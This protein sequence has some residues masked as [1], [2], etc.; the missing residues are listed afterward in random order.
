MCGRYVSTR[1]ARD[2]VDLFDVAWW[3]AGLVLAPSWNV[4]P[5]D[6]VW[7]VLERVDQDSGEVTRQLRLL[8]WGLVPLW[9]RSL[10]VGSKMINARVEKTVAQKPAFRRAWSGE[11]STASIGCG[12]R[13]PVRARCPSGGSSAPSVVAVIPGAS[14]IEVQVVRLGPA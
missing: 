8:R 5:P 1:R 7:S 13:V 10:S 4:A 9:A 3:D 12:G 6:E 14:G 2:L 11:L